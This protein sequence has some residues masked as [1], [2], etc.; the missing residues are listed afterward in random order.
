MPLLPKN[1]G[2]TDAPLEPA[3][4]SQSAL[5]CIS[6]TADVVQLH[7]KQT[8]SLQKRRSKAAR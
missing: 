1:N 2:H 7:A 8:Q 5:N 4:V 3:F 6:G